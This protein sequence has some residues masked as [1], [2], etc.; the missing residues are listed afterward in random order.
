[1]RD[2]G[3][4]GQI[5]KGRFGRLDGARRMAGLATMHRSTDLLRTRLSVAAGRASSA[6][7]SPPHNVRARMSLTDAEADTPSRHRTCG[8]PWTT[9]RRNRSCVILAVD[10]NARLPSGGKDAGGNSSNS[11][12]LNSSLLSGTTG[13]WCQKCQAEVAAMASSDNE[14][15]FCTACGSELAR[16]ASESSS[17]GAAEKA[18]GRTLSDPRELL[19]RWA[20]EDA[21]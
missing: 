21:L 20:R 6:R 8:T 12:G 18:S 19:A 14:R 4:S 9:I 3:L 2:A 11:I 15:V 13:M 10:D 17:R 1:M 5:G 7:P 16:P